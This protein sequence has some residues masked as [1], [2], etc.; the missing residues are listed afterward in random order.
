MNVVQ[1]ER[2]AAITEL[3]HSLHADRMAAEVIKMQTRGYAIKHGWTD[4]PPGWFDD[5]IERITG[6]RPDPEPPPRPPQSAPDRPGWTTPLR[7]PAPDAQR[8]FK[9]ERAGMGNPLAAQQY[10]IDPILPAET[11]GFIYGM[12]QTFKSFILLDMLL[13]SCCGIPWHGHPVI[14]RPAILI[15]GEGRASIDKRIMAWCLFNLKTDRLP[16]DALF[17]VSDRAAEFCA[18]G[19]GAQVE[20][21]IARIADHAGAIGLIGVDTVSRN[22]GSGKETNPD[23]LRVTLNKLNRHLVEPFKSC[24]IGVHHVGHAD[25]TRMRGGSNFERDGDFR[26]LAERTG[27]QRLIVLSCLKMKDDALPP[28]LAF[29][30]IM[31]E[32]AYEQRPGVPMTSLVPTWVDLPDQ[33]PRHLSQ[34]QQQALKILADLQ[35]QAAANVEAN[36]SGTPRVDKK[37]FHQE[38]KRAGMV[39]SGNRSHLLAGLKNRKLIT[40]ENG[41]LQ[42]VDIP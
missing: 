36:G 10:L 35:Q 2:L 9:L 8:P 37:W 7:D 15:P 1:D 11:L 25:K 18:N 12:D 6:R 5:L 21:E 17:L 20:A 32:L 24:C 14:K 38:L 42:L 28:P 41:Y 27:E 31:Q 22:M 29:N 26:Y 16:D 13:C 34:Q 40:E 30:L 23:D 19:N 39:D 3:A 33:A 4:L